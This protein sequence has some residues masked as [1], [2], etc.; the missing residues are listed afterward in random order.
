MYHRV[1]ELKT[2]AWDLAVSPA[3]FEC[4]LKILRKTGQVIP[5]EELVERLKT[6]TLKRRSVV[7]SFDD[8]Y[9]DNFSAAQPLL[10]DFKLPA[11]FFI[12]SGLVAGSNAFWWDVLE[13]IFL[14]ADQLPPLFSRL[15]D[16]KLLEFDLSSEQQLSDDLRQKH[17]QWKASEVPPTRRAALYY[18][19]WQILKPLAHP[20]QQQ[21]LQ[22][23]NAWAG[24]AS[25]CPAEYARLPLED[26]RQLR[27][28]L[29]CPLVLTP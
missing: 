9:A 26:L 29:V 12:T 25:S 1:A 28:P 23:I 6:G 18:R 14:A 19:L 16:G 20:A 5:V 17:R 15:V 11:A 22:Y 2:D 7:I 8:G 27:L 21:E 4:H 13:Y 24:I 10:E 3:N